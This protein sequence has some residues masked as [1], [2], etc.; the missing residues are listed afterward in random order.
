MA[1]I[2]AFDTS[3]LAGS[4]ALVEDGRIVTQINSDAATAH[5]VWLLDA[6]GRLLE[7]V[8]W[9]PVD[10]DLY[11]IAAGPGSFTGLRVGISVV[12]G[13]AWALCKKAIPISTLKAMA[14][15][16]NETGNVVC[17]VLDARKGEMYA[18][19]YLFDGGVIREVVTGSSYAP[20]AFMEELKRAGLTDNPAFL[21]SG[22]E[23]YGEAIKQELNSA[24]FSPKET[25]VVKASNIGLLANEVLDTAIEPDKLKPLYLR[26]FEPITKGAK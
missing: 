25:W 19:A 26:K 3:S 16:L 13:L 15:N 5:S 22:L 8:N 21:G 12:K 11:A 17:P 23:V 24:A 1:R 4:I 10:V 9:R 14:M 6:Y 18:A 20:A 7:S 2:A